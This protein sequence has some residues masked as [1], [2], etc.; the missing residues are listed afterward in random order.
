MALEDG[1]R[2]DVR[3][4]VD[5]EQLGEIGRNVELKAQRSAVHRPVRNNVIAADRNA[6]IID[7]SERRA[8]IDR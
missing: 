8:M 2:N 4:R 3:R 7:H 1:Q 5:S 6:E